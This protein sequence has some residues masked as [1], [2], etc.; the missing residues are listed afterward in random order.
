[1][2]APES[3]PTPASESR[4]QSAS[5]AATV[6]E[7][8]RAT[9][10]RAIAV[11]GV[12]PIAIGVIAAALALSWLP[13]LPD[14][15]AVHWSGAGPDG[16]GAPLPFILM[17]L[18]I[19]V[20]FG[21]F[22]V[23]MSWRATPSGH[24]LPGHKFLH[25]S[26]VWLATI[27]S[28]SVAGSVHAQRGLADPRDAGEIGEWMLWGLLA[29]LALAALSW[30]VPPKSRA[31]EAGAS[32]TPIETTA[33]ERLTWTRTVTI[34]PVARSIVLV[35]IAVGAASSIYVIA[36]DAHNA[37]LSAV[38]VG[39]VA[40]TA[41]AMWSWRI[42]CDRRG[43]VVRGAIGWPRVRIPLE[44][45][46]RAGTTTV[47]PAGEFGGWGWR[48]A[49][50]R[51]GLIMRAGEALEV[52]RTNGRSLVVTVDGAQTAARVLETLRA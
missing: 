16:F 50:R 4:A 2:T 39:I 6:A 46:A 44:E 18:A 17:P 1:M 8:T 40:L 9:R 34:S 22:V 19:I 14:E 29:A 3:E 10:R 13:E 41:A 52:E 36:I 24:P 21:V 43:L 47:D 51:T 7:A 27:V 11:G 5:A 30:L 25:A 20:P 49:G 33:S 23:A 15:I 35:L 28:V 48:W 12:A 31:A 32:V 38:V 45:I 42:T 26:S 37:W